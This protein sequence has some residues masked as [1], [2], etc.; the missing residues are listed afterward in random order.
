[1][2]FSQ[3]RKWT[4]C[5][6]LL[7]VLSLTAACSGSGS[8]GAS[9]TTNGNTAP[10]AECDPAN[11]ATFDECGTVYI[12]LTDADGDFVNY[13]VDVVRLTLETANGRTVETLPRSTRINFT[14]YVDVTELLTAAT[15]PP[16][17]YVAGT[18]TLNYEDAEAYVEAD[19][20]AKAA[21]VTDS[22]GTPIV[23]TELRIELSNR[24]QL[25]VR[26]GRPAILQLDFDLAASH[27]VDI[28]PTPA[29]AMAETFIVAEVNPVDEKDI[30]VRG[31]LVDVDEAA[32]S[33]TVAIRP[34]HDRI[35]DF[36]RVE[37]LTN[38]ETDFDID[39]EL[40][41]GA[42]G[43]AALAI[44]GTGTPTVAGGTLD[45]DAREFTARLVLAGSSVPGIDRDAIVGNVI[46][47]NENL[48]TIRGATFL[49]SDRRARFL[50]DVVVAVGTDTRVFKDGDRATDLGIDQISVGQRVTVRGEAEGPAATDALMPQFLFDATQGAVRLH[51]T[52]LAGTVNS[53][54]PGQLD[55][56][57][58]SIDRR[59]ASVF[60]FSGTGMSPDLDADPANYEVSTGDLL[61]DELSDVAAG[62]P[63]VAR[64]FPTAFGAAPPDFEGRTIV[65]FSD[66][67]SSLGI[68]WGSE[69]TTAPFLSLGVDGLLLD[70]QND[71]VDVRH[72]VRQGPVLIDLTALDSDTL[73]APRS[74]GRTLFAI[75]SPFSIRLYSN[76]DAFIDDLS[77]SLDGSTA[78]RS[79]HARGS[80]D[81][82]ANVFTASKIG[83]YLLESV[84]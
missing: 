30:R 25:F 54:V 53:V 47:R 10:T 40:Y 76:F 29:T 39:G 61:L 16:A 9:D 11:P 13:T 57:L 46:A 22:T 74:D 18:I 3:T 7:L 49:P 15:V 45:V 72:Y 75:K 42:D 48:L 32:G 12:G 28:T 24:D 1:M 41:S 67:R 19:G 64:G 65:D 43:L 60:D 23:E 17:T 52:R 4:E 81:A 26:R 44:A 35:G 50:E 27:L 80:Y 78:A 51:V 62:K 66:V 83:I 70:N 21:V 20:D 73:I 2:T 38:G 71:D 84:E 63:V 34:F 59:R 68:G 37:I 77:T 69:G 31:P 82:A 8:G 79:M 56:A 33:Y 36:G 55:I 5:A 14:D 58:Q 6:L